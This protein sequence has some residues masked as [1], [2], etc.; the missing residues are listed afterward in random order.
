M[1]LEHSNTLQWL[2]VMRNLMLVAEFHALSDQQSSISP[3]RKIES[4]HADFRKGRK[5]RL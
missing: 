2:E 1:F 5:D 3:S 4:R